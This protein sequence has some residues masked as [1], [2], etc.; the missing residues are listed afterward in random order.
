MPDNAPS[1]RILARWLLPLV[2]AG[3]L[4]APAAGAVDARQPVGV[5]A[6][7][8]IWFNVSSW[9]RAKIDYPKLGRYS[10]DE[11]SIMRQHIR[12]AK[13]AGIDGFIVGWK[14]TPTLDTRLRDLIRVAE[15]ER[16]RLSVAYQALDF[17][18]R[19]LPIE[20]I[21]FDLARFRRH[22]AGSPVFDGFGKPVVIWSGTWEFTP[23]QLESVAAEHRDGLRLLASERNPDG[24]LARG[25]PFEGNAYYWSSV[26]PATYP[27]YLPKLKTMSRMVHEHDGLWIAPAAPGFDARTLGRT[28]VVRRKGGETLRRQLDTAQRSE[29]DAIGLISW[30]EFSENTH[31]EPSRKYGTQALETIADVEGTDFEV[32]TDLDSSAVPREGGP[33]VSGLAATLGFVVVGLGALVF[34]SRRRRSP[35]MSGG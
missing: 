11:P 20:R 32:K 21:S 31:V 17:K 9:D 8:Y 29:P 6:Y 34:L 30:N 25:A 5:W 26:N 24:Y 35:S 2:L 33:N 28:T 18:R 27:R 7:Y 14:S 16:F 13:A 12:L 23:R 1:A 22:F 19:P 15:Q 10:S 3:L 4:A